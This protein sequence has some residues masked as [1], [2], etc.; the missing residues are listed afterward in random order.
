MN[1]SGASAGS[2]LPRLLVVCGPTAAGKSALALRLAGALPITIVSAD[3]RQIYRRFDIGTAKPTAGE[4]A[5]VPHRGVDL[6]DPTQRFSSFAWS[7]A[8]EAAIIEARQEGRIPVIVG[9][10][11]FYLRALVTPEP[12]TPRYDARYL[13]VD[14]G[15]VLRD[16]IAHRVDT[17][18]TG[19]WVDE[20]RNVGWRGSP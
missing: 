3:S 13:L 17:M 11:G 1:S 12:A 18:L 4:R 5:A 19:G 7:T 9:G 14:P 16:W 2:R 20:V 15:P 10:A 6:V 8:A